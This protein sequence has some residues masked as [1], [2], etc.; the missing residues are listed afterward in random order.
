MTDMARAIYGEAPKSD[1]GNG[2]REAPGR[3][4]P[5]SVLPP[6][7]QLGMRVPKGGSDC[8]KCEY[9]T[10]PTTC[11]NEGFVKW[12]GSPTLPAPADEYCCDLYEISDGDEDS[13]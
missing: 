4:D 6:D 3:V 1:L 5:A 9:L 8:A 10:S 11:G 2:H 7:H 12:N 13:K